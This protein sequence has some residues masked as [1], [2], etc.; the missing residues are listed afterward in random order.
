MELSRKEKISQ[1]LKGGTF[2]T[3]LTILG[4]AVGIGLGFGLRSAKDLD[5]GEKWTRREVMYIK[6]VGDLF[7]RTLGALILPL[8]VSSLIDAVGSLDLSLSKK[9]GTRALVY[10][11]GTTAV[12]AVIGLILGVTVKPGSHSNT[13]LQCD[14]QNTSTV[15]TLLD[16]VRNIFP[17]NLI[18]AT[19]Q[20]SQTKISEANLSIPFDDREITIEMAQGTNMMG[21]VV[22]SMVLGI[23]LGGMGDTGKPVL[24]F[25]KSLGEAT[26]L[27]TSKVVM[28]SPLAICFLV[29]GQ[30]VE[31]DDIGEV[32]SN[33]GWYF[34]TVMVGLLIHGIVILPAT[35][36]IFT[37]SSPIKFFTN[38]FQS[39]ATAFGTASSSA[40]LPITLN[41]LEEKNK[42]DPRVSRFVIPIGATVNMNGTALYLPVGAIYIA[43]LCGQTLS[44]GQLITVSLI[45]IAT[46]VGAAGIPQVG[47]VIMLTVLSSV[48]LPQEHIAMIMPVDW[49]LERFRTAVNVLGDAFGAGIVAQMSKS[50]L[51]K[52]PTLPLYQNEF[53]TDEDNNQIKS[54][55]LDSS[56]MVLQ[57][58]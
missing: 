8:I 50:E 58:K 2:F 27:I 33:I 7:L 45:S 22:F 39:L 19:L 5:N 26:M 4:V 20:V 30:L 47:M 42:I 24:K 36:I 18:G 14:A 37:R 49:L 43:Q 35:Y 34:G 41:C 11:L 40:A 15:D 10:Y 12:A 9:I 13:R 44:I 53:E 51:D 3:L 6:F 38:M 57:M 52:I 25:F 31:Q 46:S 16:L 56:H 29:A 28:F 55:D 32:F 17:P 21:L 48:G 54:K 23:T 1:F